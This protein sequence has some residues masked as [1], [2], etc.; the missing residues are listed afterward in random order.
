MV[1]E[2]APVCAA[3][4][5][6][7]EVERAG[8]RDEQ[9]EAERHRRVADRVHHERLLRGGDRLRTLVVEADQEVRG[10][11]DEAPADEQEQ[12]VARLHEQQH[13]EDEERHVGEEPALLV[14][15]GHVAH[16]VPDDQ[17]ADAGD[18]EHHHGGE[19]VDEDLEPDLELTGR[20]PGERPRE[21]EALLRLV[22]EQRDEGGDR[23]READEDRERPDPA[24]RAPA[25]A[26][27]GEHDQEEPGK[28]GEQAEP[29][30]AGGHP[31]SSERRST[32]S[33]SRRRLSAT[34]RPSPTHTSDAATA[35]TASANT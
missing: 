22:T 5:V 21:L 16:R 11:A 13:R 27:A 24:G 28:R 15:A 10:E 6:V 23:A 30:A 7:A 19:R 29:A 17:P 31:R 1:E 2:R 8:L 14:L 25:D 34:M 26:P 32:S 12:Q 4:N 3:K 33:A 9:E 35:I 20:E 18:D